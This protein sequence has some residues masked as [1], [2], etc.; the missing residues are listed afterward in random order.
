MNFF[1]RHPLVGLF[2]AS[3]LCFSALH[4]LNDTA[5][6]EIIDGQEYI[7]AINGKYVEPRRPNRYDIE[8][9]WEYAD[10]K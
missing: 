7:V 1:E 8:L 4:A 10:E 9:N 3:V 6:I 2:L 5:T